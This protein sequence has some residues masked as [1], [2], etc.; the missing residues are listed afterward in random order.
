MPDLYAFWSSRDPIPSYAA[1]LQMDGVIDDWELDRL[2]KEAEKLVDA[3][4]Q[5]VIAA[6]WPAPGIAG[7][8]V[9]ADAPP[10]SSA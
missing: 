7:D 4:A 2:K 10:G 6:P 3:E 5:A 9:F 8:G 1:R